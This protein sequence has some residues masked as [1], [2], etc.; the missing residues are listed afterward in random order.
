[1]LSYNFISRWFF[2][3]NHKCEIII[4]LAQKIIKN[5]FYI[6][7][8]YVK[9][10]ITFFNIKKKVK[11][12][13]KITFFK[14]IVIQTLIIVFL[15]GNTKIY[16]NL[17]FLVNAF[18]YLL[19][20]FF[21]ET[22]NQFQIL[23]I[24]SINSYKS[25]ITQNLKDSLKKNG[26]FKYNHKS[27]FINKHLGTYRKFYK[28][29]SLVKRCNTTSVIYNHKFLTS[30]EIKIL[31]T[32]CIFKQSKKKYIKLFYLLKNPKFLFI[33]YKIL[34]SK[35]SNIQFSIYNIT[36]NQVKYQWFK[37][38]AT[39]IQNGS[40]YF[41]CTQ[42]LRKKNFHNYNLLKLSKLK[43]EII[44]QSIKFILELIY[45]PTFFNYSYEYKST[46]KLHYVLKHIKLNWKN[47]S[48]ILNF[49]TQKYF[50]KYNVN[51]LINL[52]KLKI[53]DKLFINLIKRFIKKNF[54]SNIFSYLDI[55]YNIYLHELDLEII[56]IQRKFN[57]IK[58]FSYLY[59]TTKLR[60]LKIFK[61][62]VV[63]THK[64][65][66]MLNTLQ[67]INKKCNKTVNFFFEY[68]RYNNHFLFGFNCSNLIKNKIEKRITTF[69]NSNL[70]LLILDKKFVYTKSNKIE[71]L[72]FEIYFKQQNLSNNKFF[73]KKKSFKQIKVSNIKNSK[74]KKHLILI[75]ASLKNFKNILIKDKL[76]SKSNKPKAIKWLFSYSDKLIVKWFY[77]IAIKILDYYCCCENYYKIK[78]YVDYII[79][80]SALFTL[81]LKNKVTLSNLLNTMSRD[82]II[83]DKKKK[84]VLAQFMSKIYINNRKKQ[85]FNER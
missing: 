75:K 82:M 74:I 63:L 43:N 19:S 61:Y 59:D 35:L 9:F 1:M 24:Y 10:Y 22:N 13:Y 69:F 11:Q 14:R 21:Y 32:L 17:K 64:N 79:R 23:K 18:L 31:K 51:K 28:T 41:I 62:G 37:K 36:L 16:L 57:N 33:N 47:I 68:I 72:N 39:R 6:K 60:I 81:S 26:L 15:I 80:Y 20:S 40:F 73:K 84:I 34:I 49:C 70:K 83:K 56:K 65:Q 3:T 7:T 50:S 8:G 38:L 66:R 78:I 52:L 53:K 71:F 29:L 27:D 5:I 42:T 67:K 77:T 55:F 44:N 12:K 45:E 4:C 46:K 2:S 30:Y 25:C 85:F 76:M 58:N 54:Q 48:W